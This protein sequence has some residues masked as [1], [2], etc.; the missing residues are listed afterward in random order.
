MFVVIKHK[1]SF[2]SFRLL[3]WI[4]FACMI[5]MYSILIG[6][7]IR[8][9]IQSALLELSPQTLTN[10]RNNS[11]DYFS[12][13]SLATDLRRPIRGEEWSVLTST[14]NSLTA[15]SALNA[16]TKTKNKNKGSSKTNT[17]LKPSKKS[18][19]SILITRT[20]QY[21]LDTTTAH[22]E[23][24]QFYRNM[25]LPN[26]QGYMID[27][28]KV[29]NM[30]YSTFP[31]PT[32]IQDYLN[33]HQ[34]KRQTWSRD[35]FSNNRWMVIQ[36]I[37]SQLTCGGISDR[38]K[39][40]V[41]M[42][43]VAY[44]SQ[45]ILII[46]WNKPHALTE[47]LVPPKGGVDWRAPPWLTKL[48]ETPEL[49]MESGKSPGNVLD[50][51]LK[52][53]HSFIMTR[54][55]MQDYHAGRFW[56]DAQL[57]PGEVNFETIFH[58]VWKLFFTP[59]PAVRQRLENAMTEM[60]LVP[61]N[62][63]AAHCRVLYAQSD[64]PQYQQRNWAENAVNCASELRPKMDIFFTSDSADATRY[65]HQYGVSRNATLHTRIPT[66]NPPLHIEFGGPHRPASDYIDGFV[67]LYILAEATCVTYN[68][69]G[70]GV[71][72]LLM[73]RNATCGL[74]QD[75]LDRPKIHHPC[76]WVDDDPWNSTNYNTRHHYVPRATNILP[77]RDPIYLP[78]M[79]DVQS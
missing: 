60:N 64:R 1:P 72:G 67:D 5:A 2:L 12:S 8:T 71:L 55:S 61:Y 79:E 34:F 35:T 44:L 38:L 16:I 11:H 69:G 24:S 45:R 30:P 36:C 51:A 18:L 76:H 70:Y 29:W 59:S 23:L 50:L 52:R 6:T 54:M 20:P 53:T 10:V 4:M 56:Y 78:P 25:T 37:K 21:S 74:R 73:G 33:W 27:P 19:A 14:T 3:L 63:T 15:N 7:S 68:K 28:T 42:L 39:S 65:A 41:Y 43:R 75:A 57:Q 48:I 13:V 77:T 46:H 32:W 26:G 47:F 62:Y 17:I 58:H 66:P 40:I 49:G 31:Y 9:T 22:I